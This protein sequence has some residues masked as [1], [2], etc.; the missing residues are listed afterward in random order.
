MSLST[1]PTRPLSPPSSPEGEKV[2]PRRNSLNTPTTAKRKLF[3]ESCVVKRNRPVSESTHSDN[4]S[5]YTTDTG[6]VKFYHLTAG[7]KLPFDTQYTSDDVITVLHGA[8]Y[9]SVTDYTQEQRL[10]ALDTAV[11]KA[12]FEYVITAGTKADLLV[13]RFNRQ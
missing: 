9:I 1:S 13:T 3:D 2:A 8:V 6:S 7:D 12:G 11:I 5:L 4:A 10:E